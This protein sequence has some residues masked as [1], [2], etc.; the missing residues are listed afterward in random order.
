FA[1]PRHPYTVALL[2]AVPT[3]ATRATPAQ[4]PILLA[5]DP[6]SP[7]RLPAGCRFHTRCWLREALGNPAICATTAPAL[8]GENGHRAACRLAAER[9][10]PAA[11]GGAAAGQA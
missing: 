11:A 1:E 2:S 8:A 4:D 3:L 7:V 10:R 6:P 9:A 5:G